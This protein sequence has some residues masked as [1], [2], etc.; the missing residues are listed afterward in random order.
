MSS[1]GI[2]GAALPGAGIEGT[3]TLTPDLPRADDSWRP[4]QRLRD[5]IARRDTNTVAVIVSTEDAELRHPTRLGDQPFMHIAAAV[6][7]P[8]IMAL[9]RDANLGCCHDISPLTGATPLHA[10]AEG[11]D[12]NS[13]LAWLLA[14]GA[15]P[16]ARNRSGYV[17]LHAA[18]HRGRAKSV[19]LLLESGATPDGCAPMP[20]GSMMTPLW[21]AAAGD[22]QRAPLVDLLI[23]AGANPDPTIKGG[24]SALMAAARRGDVEC[25]DR[26]LTAGADALHRTDDG[27]TAIHL[28]VEGRR[29][30]A[31]TAEARSLAQ[32]CA[33]LV[34]AGADLD[35][36]DQRG[37]T[38]LLDAAARGKLEVVEVLVGMGADACATTATGQSAASLIIRE[39]AAPATAAQVQRLR[40]SAA[41]LPEHLANRAVAIRMI[42]DQQEVLLRQRSESAVEALRLLLE[43]CPTLVIH[44]DDRGNGL[45]H[46][47]ARYADRAV[48]EVLLAWAVPQSVE[49]LDGQTP[50][51]IVE[52]RNDPDATPMIE[53][54]R[55]KST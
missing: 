34:E 7:S 37:I 39:V 16:D 8:Q 49:N 53:L 23:E 32:T 2:I 20:A 15:E 31:G 44:L 42:A 28:A 6:D 22:G 24:E 43:E 45:A 25:V 11:T 5:A 26:L 13:A 40:E 9:L 38:P 10:A 21:S 1:S 55:S 46:A 12:G 33:R 35:A 17:P 52:G 4:A 29:W 3:S 14:N 50:H 30:Q 48:L 27:R 51:S 47:A 41:D 54:L 18:A 36:R 19:Q